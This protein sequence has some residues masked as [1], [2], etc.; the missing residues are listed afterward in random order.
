MRWVCIFSDGLPTLRSLKQSSMRYAKQWIRPPRDIP[1]KV[2]SKKLDVHATTP[3]RESR[4]CAELGIG[5]SMKAQEIDLTV[6][7][8]PHMTLAHPTAPPLPAI[9]MASGSNHS[10]VKC[11][12]SGHQVPARKSAGTLDQL[13]SDQSYELP[14]L[15]IA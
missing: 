4:L 10:A 14:S 7:R 8:H 15:L 3:S 11:L 6:T 1:A 5:A 13:N 9:P 2:L 12:I